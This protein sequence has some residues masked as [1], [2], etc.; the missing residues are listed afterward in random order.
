M[1]NDYATA[2]AGVVTPGII[3]ST[4]LAPVK[5]AVGMPTAPVKLVTSKFAPE[6]LVFITVASKNW[7]SLKFAPVASAPVK[8]APTK[9]V[10]SAKVLV[11]TLY[12]FL[13]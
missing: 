3:A 9:V 8:S 11:K 1:L 13:V 7:P 12:A 5:S 10:F 2:G 4:R 6:K